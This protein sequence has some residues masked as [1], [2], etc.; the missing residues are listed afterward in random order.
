MGVIWS[1]RITPGATPIRIFFS[2]IGKHDLCWAALCLA[3]L[4]VAWL[5]FALLC[6]AWLGF[7]LFGFVLFGL[8]WLCL[9]WLGLALLGFVWL[10]LFI[11]KI[12]S[13]KKIGH[14]CVI[15]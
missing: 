6:L 15:I 8:A 14:D 9:A 11:K 2:L 3:R 10:C 1:N 12:N 7:V 13:E 5:C 4:G